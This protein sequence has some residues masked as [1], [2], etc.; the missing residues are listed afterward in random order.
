[1]K[2]LFYLFLKLPKS[3]AFKQRVVASRSQLASLS[4]NPFHLTLLCALLL[5]LTRSTMRSS[6]SFYKE[7]MAEVPLIKSD[8]F[9]RPWY[10][11]A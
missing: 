3:S 7:V 10:G 5:L 8:F 4:G 1:M 2:R 11:M 6:A 9:H